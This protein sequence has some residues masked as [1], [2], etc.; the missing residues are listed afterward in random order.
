MSW[1]LV[2]A[3]GVELSG[4][5]P[6]R[7][8]RPREFDGSA[9]GGDL[10][11]HR[12][13]WPLSPSVAYVSAGRRTY[14]LRPPDAAWVPAGLP[15]TVH[16]APPV[17]AARFRAG[18]CPARW[19]YSA[20]HL[21]LEAGVTS[22]LEWL[23][24]HVE[25]PWA[26]SVV[27]AVV[28]Q[29]ALAHGRAR[30]DLPLP[31]TPVLRDVALSLLDNPG[32][33][34]DVTEWA[35][36][37]GYT[38]RSFRRRFVVETGIAFAHWRTE[39]RLNA[40]MASLAAGQT[41]EAVARECGYRSS[42]AFSRA[43]RTATGLPPSRF[44]WSDHHIGQ[45]LRAEWPLMRDVDGDT[46]QV[47]LRALDMTALPTRTAA[48]A[49]AGLLLLS[50]ACGSDSDDESASASVE[51]DASES[52]STSSEESTGDEQSGSDD[53]GTSDGGGAEVSG[54][55]FPVTVAH[56]A[57]ET[58]IE[59]LPERVF[60]TDVRWEMAW[61]TALGVTPMGY[62]GFANGG[63]W[64]DADWLGDPLP[65]SVVYFETTA[66]YNYEE[67][68]ALEPDLII[69]TGVVGRDA[70]V[71]TLS[72]SAPV[73]THAGDTLESRGRPIAEA[74]GR[75]DRYEE[76]LD[77][78]A[79]EVAQFNTELDDSATEASVS[80]F[81]FFPD[82]QIALYGGDW[83]AAD[84]LYGQL[85]LQLPPGYD[86]LDFPENGDELLLSPEQIESVSGDILVCMTYNE[87]SAQ[88]CSDFVDDPLAQ[89]LE[90]VA[91]GRVASVP[92]DGVNLN[93]TPQGRR[94]A[95]QLLASEVLPL[96]E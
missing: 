74:L 72:E 9:P 37:A 77:E 83:W 92:F 28:D 27:S 35:R 8:R 47:N 75:M 63:Q 36:R 49:G 60:L 57:G 40:A 17:G 4:L 42:T 69:H 78:L 93:S 79:E 21:V 80:F 32:D 25:R 54:G 2:T 33:E 85:G 30:V 13:V 96:M 55:P 16:G 94:A 38:P 14:A 3:D 5:G 67:I 89:G 7:S 88:A 1:P 50:A 82:G 51:S 64:G 53:D 86:D 34:S 10:I 66:E 58:T 91:A 26:S 70:V 29:I 71:D 22:L 84:F 68:A 41:V 52:A 56:P 31:V 15:L 23:P 81:L 6:T 19:A 59:A 73:V 48:L 39:V 87:E 95:M 76:I 44:T 61:V 12:L 65:D 18:S 46:H 24:A 43:F 62:T 90:S 11:H 20:H 45:S